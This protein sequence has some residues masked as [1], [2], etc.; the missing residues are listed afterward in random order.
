MS[1][2]LF[3]SI[4]LFSSFRKADDTKTVD[5]CIY[6]GTSGGVIAAYTAKQMGKSVLLIEPRK[7]LGGMSSGGLGQTDIGNKYVVSGLALDFYRRIGAHYGELEQ[8]IFEPKVAEAIFNDYIDRANIEVWYESRL[9]RVKKKKNTIKEITLESTCNK[10]APYKRVKA[11]MFIDCTYEGDLMAKAGVTYTIGREANSLYNETYNGVQLREAH[12]FDV[13]IDPYKVPAD[14]S[15]GLLWGITDETLKSSG[16][17]DHK[18]QAYNFRICLTNNKENMIPITRPENYDPSKYE[19]LVRLAEKSNWTSLSDLMILSR[20]PNN[21][22]DI[23][24]RGAFSSDMIGANWDY[25]DANYDKRDKIWKA[26][27]DYNKGLLYFIGHNERMPKNIR[28]LMLAWGYPKD[29]YINNRNWS[30]QLYVREARRMVSD[31]VM[32]QHHCQGREVI[33]DA[34]GWAAYRMDSHNCDRLVVNG[35]V[36]NEGDVQI[37]GFGPFPIS[38]RSIVPKEKEVNNLLVPF[39][40]SASHIAFGSIRME[41]VFMVLSQSSAVAA[42]LAIDNT[43]HVVQ[44]VDV[45]KIQQVLT[46]NPLADNTTPDL[47]I[48]NHNTNLVTLNGNWE[49]STYGAYGPN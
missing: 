1:L 37:G 42:C 46:T 7:N 27:E 49:T 19:M 47:V 24:N 5:I 44:E 30:H 13:D 12:Q 26:H 15:S 29:E 33:K 25:P 34:V 36:M 8:W 18:V 40:L 35:L 20:M 39:C 48:D 2:I 28:D 16:T 32:T 22:T 38:Y 43:N 14:K 4:F 23:N 9:S 41:P 11:K 45:A 6:G 3:L 21:K 17:G 31:V 10:S